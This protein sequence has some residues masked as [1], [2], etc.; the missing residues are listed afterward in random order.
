[1]NMFWVLKILW[2]F[3]GANRKI[4][5]TLGVISMYFMVFSYYGQGTEWGIF[6]GGC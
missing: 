3:F 1:M 2:I 6:L 4:E 5:L